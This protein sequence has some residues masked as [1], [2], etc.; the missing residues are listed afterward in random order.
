MQA[1]NDFGY[2]SMTAQRYCRVSLLVGLRW[3]LKIISKLHAYGGASLEPVGCYESV[4]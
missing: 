4:P 2:A 3:T 1:A